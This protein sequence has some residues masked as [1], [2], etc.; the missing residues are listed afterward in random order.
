MSAAK[1]KI[2]PELLKSIVAGKY[3]LIRNV[4]LRMILGA[5]VGIKRAMLDLG[6]RDY[7]SAGAEFRLWWKNAP[8]WNA[9]SLPQFWGIRFSGKIGKFELWSVFQND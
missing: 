4:D 9:T 2:D 6:W 5:S 3:G 1:N 7:P 8:K